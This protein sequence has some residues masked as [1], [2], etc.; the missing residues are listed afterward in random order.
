[1][2]AAA[3]QVRRSERL[4]G[5][6]VAPQIDA[7]PVGIEARRK[8]TTQTTDRR[9]A[10]TLRQQQP[11][12]AGHPSPDYGGA[13]NVVDPPNWYVPSEA[14]NVDLLRDYIYLPAYSS[15]ERLL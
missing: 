5:Q 15:R 13:P 6:A 3:L 14:P 1:M 8:R 4:R 2:E 7:V 9:R 11:H 12:L 10:K